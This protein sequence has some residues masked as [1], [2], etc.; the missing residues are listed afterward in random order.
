MRQIAARHG[1]EAVAFSQSS[2]ST[3]AIA[4]AG[5]FIRRLMN[6]FGTPNCMTNLDICGWGRAYATRFTYGVASVGT[7]SGGGAMPDLEHSGCLILWGYNPS[8][9]R[10]THATAVVH[11]R[12]RGMRLIVVDPRA[13]G[14]ANKADVWLR[15][16]PGTDGALAL[17]LAN[18]MIERGWYDVE[19]I[20]RWTNGPFLVRADTGRLLTEHDLTADGSPRRVLAWDASRARP[21]PYDVD[22]GRYELAEVSPALEGEYRVATPM[23]DVV[24]HPA[25]ELYARLCRRYPPE[26]TERIC[27]VPRA[28]L[29]HAAQVIWHA[30]PVSYYAWSGHEQHASATQT[31]RAMSLLYALTGCF[32]ARGGNVVFPSPAAGAITGEELPAARTMAPALGL[33]DRPLGPARWGS[34]TTRELYRAILEQQPYAVRALLGFGSNMLIAHPDGAYGRRA[35]AALEF[36][37]H[38]DLFMTPTAELADVVLPVASAFERE[39]LKIGFEISPEAQ[40]RIQLRPAVVAPPGEARS[41]TA[42]VFELARRLG[43]GAAFWSGNVEDAYRQQLA[44]TGVTSSCGNGVH[45]P[46]RVRYDKH[47]EPDASGAPRGFATPSRKVELYSQTLLTHGYAP[48]PEFE[49]PSIGPVARPDLAARFPLVLTT[50]KS[51][52]FCQSQHR[53]LATLRRR[54]MHPEIELHPDTARARGIAEGDWVSIE[55]LEG[56]VRARA[57]FND[58]LDARVVV[59]Q[60]GWWQGCAELGAPAYDP[61]ASDGANLNL[62]LG[63]QA[64]DPVSGTASHRAYLCDVRG[65]LSRVWLVPLCY[66]TARR[67]TAMKRV[68]VGLAIVLVL[69]AALEPAP[70][71]AGGWRHG[72][73]G[74][75]W[76]PGAIVGGLVLGAVALATAPLWALTPPPAPEPVVVQ[77]APTVVQAPAPTYSAP[78]L[79]V[80]PPG[81]APPPRASQPSAYA[82]AAPAVKREVVYEHGRYVLYGDGVRQPWQWVWV[83]AAAPPPPPPPPPR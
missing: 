55:T 49:E 5:A 26:T 35:L 16:R 22:A 59:G 48:L 43:H 6:A 69:L 23:G 30:R 63:T 38:A 53:A 56:R 34:I 12:A 61:F 67:R 71:F 76:L 77:A 66:A 11:A 51:A 60:H 20:R 74:G 83:P 24:C 46:L 14:L 2:P 64:L 47:A 73:H 81:S 50:A 44:G 62:I 80:P 28:Q 72:H 68:V 27:W 10:I 1:P 15:V 75:W 3:T 42:I 54:A 37:A 52:L 57:R 32:D 39:A 29:E 9:S 70:A 78:L 65:P 21:T 36:Y 79:P 13:A 25:F 33:S 31:A 4:D 18:L 45:V 40:S 82:A 58:A 8:Y 19:F 17:G 7:G 41:D